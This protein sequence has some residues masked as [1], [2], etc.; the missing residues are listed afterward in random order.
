[1]DRGDT[2][3]QRKYD[4]IEVVIRGDQPLPS[5]EEP[6][7]ADGGTY[8]QARLDFRTRT[9]ELPVT[10]LSFAD[11]HALCRAIIIYGQ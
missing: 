6:I 9:V 8:A 11:V 4:S 7:S 10:T 3:K 1:M 2:M 5:L